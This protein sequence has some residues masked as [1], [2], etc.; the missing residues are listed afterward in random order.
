MGWLKRAAGAH[1]AIPARGYRD[2]PLACSLPGLTGMF[3]STVLRL[4]MG[5]EGSV[6]MGELTR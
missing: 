5:R 6:H 2:A 1:L 4:T 3:V